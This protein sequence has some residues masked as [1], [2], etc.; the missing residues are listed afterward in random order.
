MHTRVRVDGRHSHVAGS[1]VKTRVIR[2]R[3]CTLSS[4]WGGAIRADQPI[5]SRCNKPSKTKPYYSGNVIG[6]KSAEIRR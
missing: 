1:S 4:P 6:D 2:A 5:Q 3:L